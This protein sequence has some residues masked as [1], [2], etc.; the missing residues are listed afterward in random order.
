MAKGWGPFL[1][2]HMYMYG[3]LIYLVM[4]RLMLGRMLG[5]MLRR[6]RA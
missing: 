2:V 6:M 1:C 3:S 5:R 4:L